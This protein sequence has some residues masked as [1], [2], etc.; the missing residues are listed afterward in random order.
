[1]TVV[2][3]LTVLLVLVTNRKLPGGGSSAAGGES[4]MLLESLLTPV[5][6]KAEATVQVLVNK[7]SRPLN[8]KTR[9][10]RTIT[11]LMS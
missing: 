4:A 5:P 2:T 11:Y 9:S 6:S 10:N 3:A 8:L 1:V 7:D